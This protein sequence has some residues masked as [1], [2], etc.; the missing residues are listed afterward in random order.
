MLKEG[1]GLFPDYWIAKLS[2]EQIIKFINNDV[3]YELLP[4]PEWNLHG[5]FEKGILY[6]WAKSLNK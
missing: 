6:N 1:I 5:F 3:G 2:E 4:I